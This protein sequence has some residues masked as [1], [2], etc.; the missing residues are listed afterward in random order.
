[1]KTL[2]EPEGEMTWIELLMKPHLFLKDSHSQLLFCLCGM[3]K[4]WRYHQ[5]LWWRVLNPRKKW[6]ISSGTW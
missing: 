5:P 3:E 2:E 6:R 4:P 1:V